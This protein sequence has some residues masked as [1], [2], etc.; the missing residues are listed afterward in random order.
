M[1]SVYQQAWNIDPLSAWNVGNDSI[2][3]QVS[4]G[5]VLFSRRNQ[6]DGSDTSVFP[7]CPEGVC[8]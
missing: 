4:V 6:H 3:M 2:L 5:F 1:N 8:C 7:T